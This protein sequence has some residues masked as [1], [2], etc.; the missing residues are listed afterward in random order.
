MLSNKISISYGVV[1]VAACVLA[2]KSKNLAW[3]LLPCV[4]NTVVEMLHWLTGYDAIPSSERTAFFYDISTFANRFL[5]TDDNYSDGY[6]PERNLCIPPDEA[7]H[8]KFKEIWKRLGVRPGDIVLDVGSGT[9]LLAKFFEKMGAKVVGMTLSSGQVEYCR[10]NG[11]RAFKWDFAVENRDLYNKFDHIVFMGASEHVAGGHHCRAGSYLAKRE[12]MAQVFR[13]L[14][15]YLKRGGRLFH[16][17]L[18][19]SP[20]TSCSLGHYL[21]QRTYGGLLG[22]DAPGYDA[23][24]SGVDAHLRVVSDSDET[25][26]YY[27]ATVTNERHFGH[28]LRVHGVASILMLLGSIA[29]PPLFLMWL[30][31]IFGAW[32]WMFDGRFHP[33]G[34]RDYGLTDDRPVSLK[35]TVFE[36]PV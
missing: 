7:T 12:R 30:Y 6:Y 28:S 35:W 1:F 11:F 26:G 36:K 15:R 16:S 29:C 24:T 17:S 18:H 31:Y 23:A 14:S 5:H 27:A 9:C 20:R 25:F 10:K 13:V 32:M 2:V 19:I 22:L 3:I 33:F 21:L 4:V 8:N 34:K